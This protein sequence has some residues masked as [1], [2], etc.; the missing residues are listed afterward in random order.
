MLVT[1]EYTAL[2]SFEYRQQVMQLLDT[3]LSGDQV[4]SFRNQFADQWYDLHNPELLDESQQMVVNFETTAQDFP[5]NL[6][7]VK[8][9]HIILYFARKDGSPL[10]FLWLTCA[11]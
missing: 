6:N 5:P 4:F 9:Q 8:I 2:I 1:I 10:N 3:G 7:S 11:H